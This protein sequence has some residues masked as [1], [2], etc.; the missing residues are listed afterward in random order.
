MLRFA[1]HIHVLHLLSQIPTA[2]P[3]KNPYERMTREQARD[4]WDHLFHYI[5]ENW[6]EPETAFK[7]IGSTW[8][9]FKTEPNYQQCQIDVGQCTEMLRMPAAE[10][11]P[12]LESLPP[13]FSEVIFPVAVGRYLLREM[14]IP[15][16]HRESATFRE[17][18]RR[19][20]FIILS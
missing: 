19:Y 15:L 13:F 4:C 5:H 7:D 18:H 12:K 11:V 1:K 20:A 6:A 3:G 2:E 17:F 16:D 14:C 10:F 9:E 8:G